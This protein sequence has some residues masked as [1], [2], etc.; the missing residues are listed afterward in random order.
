[1]MVGDV[2]KV[3]TYSQLTNQVVF[4]THDESAKCFQIEQDGEIAYLKYEIYLDSENAEQVI[5]FKS[6]FVPQALRG[7]GIAEQMVRTGLAWA[8]QENFKIVASCWYVEKF[9]KMPKKRV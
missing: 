3:S 5:D 8:K 6:T 2:D 1:M 7:K 9:L 4:M